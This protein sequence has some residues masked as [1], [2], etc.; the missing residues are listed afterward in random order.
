MAGDSFKISL[1]TFPLN[2]LPMEPVTNCHNFAHE[3]TMHPLF[4]KDIQYP[5][6]AL[7]VNPL[8][9]SYHHGLYRNL[10]HIQ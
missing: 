2:M 3:N 6:F 1:P 8:L 5:S 4:F 9:I 10:E 7:Y